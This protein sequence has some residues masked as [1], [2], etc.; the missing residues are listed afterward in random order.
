MVRGEL[1]VFPDILFNELDF[2]CDVSEFVEGGSD[3]A[4]AVNFFL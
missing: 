3:K 1:W 4:E 2:P